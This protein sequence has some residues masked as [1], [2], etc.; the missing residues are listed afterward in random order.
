MHQLRYDAVTRLLHTNHWLVL[1]LLGY[2]LDHDLLPIIDGGVHV[3][4]AAVRDVL[5][6]GQDKDKQNKLQSFNYY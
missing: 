1:G 3:G 5:C 4:V 6:T 2:H